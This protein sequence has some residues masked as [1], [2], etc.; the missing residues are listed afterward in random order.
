MNGY[1]KFLAL[2][3]VVMT[4]SVALSQDPNFHIFLL[5][6]QSNMEGAGKIESQDKTGVDPRFQV[7][8]AVDCTTADRSLTIGQWSIATPPLFRCST[9]LGIGDY[10]GRTMVANLPAPIKIGVVPVAI[11]GCDIVLFDKVNYG[12]YVSNAPSWMKDIIA[13]YGGDPYRRLLEVA[14]LA[15]KDGVIKGIL[16]HQGETNTSNPDWKNKVGQVVKNLKADLELGDIPFLAGELLTGQD[17]CCSSHNVEVNKLPDIIPNA[18][19][20]SSGELTG[21]DYAHFTSASYRTFGE[22]YAKKM[23]E[24]LNIDS[25]SNATTLL[26]K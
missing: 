7:M 16:F 14:R 4:P 5:L 3:I 11:G 2:L 22:R 26:K 21:A 24:L 19:V 15:K 18:H 10:F 13:Q 8:G 1:F 17:A 25:T 23:I 6:G 12:P 9:G 20:I